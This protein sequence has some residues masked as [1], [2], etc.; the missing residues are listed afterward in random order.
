M[1]ILRSRSGWESAGQ[2]KERN[3][4]RQCLGKSWDVW[5][6]QLQLIPITRDEWPSTETVHRYLSK[7]QDLAMEWFEKPAS[8]C[9]GGNFMPLTQ[10]L[11]RL[12]FP[13]PSDLLAG[14]NGWSTGGFSALQL[15]SLPPHK[16]HLGEARHLQRLRP[17]RRLGR[18]WSPP[19]AI[20][21]AALPTDPPSGGHGE[22]L[23][24]RRWPV[25]K[26]KN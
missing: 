24:Q 12:P 5:I 17:G 23:T 7:E 6:Q 10:C 9:L 14:P 4:E 3:W 16:D 21:G 22:S 2:R 20:D 18:A 25:K 8:W 13:L 15:R 19:E 11:P 1:A 26:Q